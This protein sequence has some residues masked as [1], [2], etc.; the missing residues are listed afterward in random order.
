ML[1]NPAEIPAR[2]GT[3]YPEPFRALVAGRFRKRL[4]DA[5]GL[6]NFG[7]NWV[8]LE[9]GSA[10][11]HRHWHQRQDELIYVL[12]GEL[13]LITNAGEQIL[14]AGMAAGFPAGEADGHHLVNRSSSPAIYLEVGDR[15]SHDTV[16]YPDIDLL[17]QDSPT[18]WV[19]THKNGHPYGEQ[20]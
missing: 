3:G 8:L 11:A 10:S 6:K 14:T 7:V 19:F 17:A 12:E 20:P 1:I 18:G 16:T 13:T 9:P 5:A 2:T 15:T 4:G